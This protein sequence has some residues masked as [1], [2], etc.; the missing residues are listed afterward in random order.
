MNMVSKEIHGRISLRSYFQFFW[1]RIAR[2]WVHVFKKKIFFFFT[3]K[4]LS[5]KAV[6]IYV[7]LNN[8]CIFTQQCALCDFSTFVI[9]MRD[10]VI[11]S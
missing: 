5:I 6:I 2:S 11:S 7:P 8:K 4:M 1:S 9:L 3:A 10:K